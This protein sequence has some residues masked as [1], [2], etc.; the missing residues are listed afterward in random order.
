MESKTKATNTFTCYVPV[1]LNEEQKERARRWLNFRHTGSE[2]VPYE[3]KVSKKLKNSHY[4]M[5]AFHNL[6]CDMELD[7]D[8]KFLVKSIHIDG[9]SYS[10]IP[11]NY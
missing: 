5:N 1:G 4:R 2:L 11:S 7:E 3:K 8:G 6:V 10:V 9:I